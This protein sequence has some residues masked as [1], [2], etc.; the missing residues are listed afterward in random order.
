MAQ[1]VSLAYPWRILCAVYAKLVAA[2]LQHW[3]LVV[4][5]WQYPD[6][7]LPKALLTLRHHIGHIANRPCLRRLVAVG[8]RLYGRLPLLGRWL[9]PR[10]RPHGPYHHP[11]LA[12][13]SLMPMGVR[14]SAPSLTRIH[15]LP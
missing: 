9:S 7:S 13:L 2:L 10:Q 1:P 11:T 4:G 3:L 14:T 12:R 15:V 5:C 8:E 6:R